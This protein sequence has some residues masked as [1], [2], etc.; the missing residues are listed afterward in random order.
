[1]KKAQLLHFAVTVLA[2]ATGSILCSFLRSPVHAAALGAAVQAGGAQDE[3]AASYAEH[4]AICHG[5]HREGN[6]PAFPPLTG[7]EHQMSEAQIADIIQK[8][9]DRMPGFPEIKDPE[10]AM[11]LHFVSTPDA[12]Q[13]AAA[14][15]GGNAEVEAGAAIFKQNCSFCHGRD[16]QGGETGPDL[17]QSK[18][19]LADKTGDAI[20]AVVREG[21]PAKKMPPFKFSDTELH[22]LIAFIR[23]RVAL[24]EAHPGGRRGVDV[25][26]LQTGN[27]E[28]GKAYFNGAGGCARCHSPTGDLSGIASRLEGLK[29]EEQMLYPWEA[30]RSVTVTEA[31]GKKVTGTLIYEDE[32]SV[33]L[34][35]ADG[36]HR[37]W[38][39]N[40]VRYKIDAPVE[41]HVE[42]FPKYTDDDIH[43]LMAYL[44]TLR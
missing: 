34:R 44:Q 38:F 32:F 24:A 26:D 8:G 39:K 29:L 27:A 15:S 14:G 41:A 33:A 4:C 43:N 1:M 40:R 20:A 31:S 23:D 9:K 25:A 2:I 11:L 12:S 42:L 5:D 30:K 21:R 7:I 35:E 10:L 13:R 36:T 28:A 6:L 3:G 17:T 19:V 18:L 22:G 37:S 16:A